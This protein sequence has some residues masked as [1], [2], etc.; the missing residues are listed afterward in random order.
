MDR[1]VIS[2]TVDLATGHKTFTS[3]Y[4]TLAVKG[5]KL[6]IEW[7]VTLMIDG[8]A[9]DVSGCSAMIYGI[10]PDG[11]TVLVNGTVNGSVCT[12]TLSQQFMALLGKVECLMTLTNTTDHTTITVSHITLD[13]QQGPTDAIIDPGDILPDISEGLAAIEQLSDYT[14]TSVTVSGIVSV[15]LTNTG[16]YEVTF[17]DGTSYVLTVDGE[18]ITVN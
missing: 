4:S 6:S 15:E 18:S 7:T 9:A 12:A 14:F 1:W 10:R 2:E 5:D 13:V 3:G 11:S 16:T 8:E 17:T